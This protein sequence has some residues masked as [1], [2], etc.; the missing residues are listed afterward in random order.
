MARSLASQPG[1]WKA[2]GN[3]APTSCCYY[4]MN[5]RTTSTP[6]GNSRRFSRSPRTTWTI[7]S[8]AIRTRQHSNFPGHFC[9]PQ[10]FLQPA[11]QEM[12]NPTAARF[13]CVLVPIR[14]SFPHPISRVQQ[15]SLDTTRTASCRGAEK[16][17]PRSIMVIFVALS[18]R[19]N[20]GWLRM[21]GKE[22]LYCCCAV[23][24]YRSR[25]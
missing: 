18:A 6:L 20:Q 14:K 11:V 8:C 16:N 4:I 1:L 21:T 3:Q 10:L 13:V 12:Q 15:F 24:A 17:T 5:E 19:E 23:Y 2:R 9:S 25:P 22:E 7:I